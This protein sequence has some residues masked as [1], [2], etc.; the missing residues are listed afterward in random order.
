MPV[1]KQR[2]QM[3]DSPYTSAVHCAV[4][5][6][7]TEGPRA[8]Y[9]SYWTQLAMNVPF[10]TLHFVTYEY[11]R[12]SLNPR[13]VYDPPSHM[14]AGAGAGALAAAATTPLDVV[15]TLLNTQETATRAAAPPAAAAYVNSTLDAVRTIYARSGLPGFTRG[16]G[17]RI[18]FQMPSTAVC[19]TVYEFFKHA[20]QRTDGG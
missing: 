17:A 13:G 20:L 5:T 15:K 7:R 16:L 3:A 11:L 14:L 2:L 8:F 12:K 6:A 9:R 18:V 4:D 19:W 10:Q 1:V